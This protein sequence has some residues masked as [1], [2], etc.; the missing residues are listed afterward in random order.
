M[1]QL[2]KLLNLENLTNFLLSLL[3]I[4]LIAGSLIVNLNVLLFLIAGIILVKEAGGY[5]TDFEGNEIPSYGE[6]AFIT[7]G[8][9]GDVN[10]DGEVNVLDVVIVVNFALYFEEPSEVEFWASDLNEDGSI[11][12]LDVVLLVGIILED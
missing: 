5:I 8:S 1:F 4:S 2:K 6:D 10:A 3:P 11:N 7:I 12:V 9:L